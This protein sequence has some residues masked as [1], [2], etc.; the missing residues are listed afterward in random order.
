MAI[1][2]RAGVEFTGKKNKFAIRLGVSYMFSLGNHWSLGPEAFLDLIETGE[3]LGTVPDEI[4]DALPRHGIRKMYLVELE[5]ADSKEELPVPTE[6]QV[7]LIGTHDT[8]TLAG[9]IAD[10]LDNIDDASRVAEI[11]EEVITLCRR[12]PVYQ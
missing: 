1:H 12:F 3:N 7:A 5:A 11:R 9:W 10:I 6:D 2:R 8:P 4:D